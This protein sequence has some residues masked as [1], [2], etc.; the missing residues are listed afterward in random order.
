MS[1]QDSKPVLAVDV[2]EVLADHMKILC[3]FHNQTYGSD[4]TPDDFH[5]YQFHEV[6]GGSTDESKVKV[7]A[8]NQSELFQE[9]PP[10]EGSVEYIHK[11]SQYF[12]L[13]IVTSRSFVL[14]E[15]TKQ[16]VEKHFPN[17]FS[18]IHFGNH[19]GTGGTVRSKPQMCAEAG[20]IMLIDD[21]FDYAVQCAARG[22]PVV[23]FGDYAWSRSR[24]LTPEENN[25]HS[26]VRRANDW[27][28]VYSII[29]NQYSQTLVM[30][31]FNGLDSLTKK[32]DDHKIE[33]LP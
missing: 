5:S 33:E 21:S 4:L 18:N 28:T 20:A 2:D 3:V 1:S 22:I 26:L 32:D 17:L 16:W 6:W 31:Q 11:L 19:Y 13:Q 25:L 8:F 24:T 23:L 7:T 9:I 10:V 27:K 15:S 29:Q 30:Q 14:E 12:D